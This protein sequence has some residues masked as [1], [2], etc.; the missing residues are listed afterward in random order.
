MLAAA[1]GLKILA[2]SQAA[3]ELRGEHEFVL[4]PLA[5]PEEQAGSAGSVGA[6]P[7]VELFVERAREI[8][9]DFELTEENAA[10]VA[11]ICRRLDGLP[12]A[13]ELAASLVK[14]LSPEAILR[15]LDERF[16]LLTGG[17]R[18]VPERHRTLRSAI[19]WSYEQ[20]E[21]DEQRLFV[22]LGVFVGG[23]T[24][25]SIAAVCD[26]PEAVRPGELFELL[27]ALVDKSLVLQRPGPDGEPR[28]A[29]LES[30]RLYALEQS[31]ERVSWT[32]SAIGT[33]DI[34]SVSSRRPS[35]S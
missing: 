26:D 11:Q 35:P 28:F 6:A 5:L 18:D 4:S 25:E 33:P 3:L 12:L 27:G 19:D 29:T 17:A 7:A 30:V 13:I 23:S 16:E 1:G 15:R 14:L 34:S 24:F 31:R 22:R 21:Q 8:R 32:S 20:L 2:T 9:P 10:T